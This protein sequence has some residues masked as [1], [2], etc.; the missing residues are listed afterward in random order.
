MVS[1]PQSARR[2]EGLL[3]RSGGA[4]LLLH[5]ERQHRVPHHH[6]ARDSPRVRPRTRPSVRR[7]RY[8]IPELL[9]REDERGEREGRLDRKSTR[10]NS[11]HRCISY[12]VFCLKKKKRLERDVI[13]T[14][15]AM[16]EP[17]ER[18]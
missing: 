12:A 14:H 2:M 1:P 18:R 8:P 10:L 4:P 9:R 3:V 17:S 13:N 11:S 6:L 5:R 15:H 7:T 16:T